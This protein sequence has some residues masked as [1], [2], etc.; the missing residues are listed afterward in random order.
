M[1][2]SVFSSISSSSISASSGLATTVT[3]EL[4]RERCSSRMREGA[5]DFWMYKVLNDICVM[6]RR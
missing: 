1:R 3:P 5:P 2:L 4:V 6:P